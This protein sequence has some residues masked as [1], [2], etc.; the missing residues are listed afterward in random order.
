MTNRGARESLT[1]N[2]ATTDASA[3]DAALQRTRGEAARLLLGLIA[4]APPSFP[5]TWS[6]VGQAESP[7]G[8]ADVVDV[9]GPGDFAVRLFVDAESHLPLM[10]TYMAPEPRVVMR[11]APGRDAAATVDRH[12]AAAG[13]AAG[14][15]L[16]PE[17]RERLE[18]EMRDTAGAPKMVE[19]RMFF[20]D[21]RDVGGLLLP[22]R[23]SRGTAAKTNEEWEIS[24]YTLNP[25]FKADR[26]KVGVK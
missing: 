10:L 23:I 24:R 3:K 9:K 13:G 18:K 15:E 19:M 12:G 4:G 16:S 7:D 8:K 20:A 26:F 11:A 21:Y 1:N 2:G 5:V 14:R 22:H 25:S 17:E 6:Y